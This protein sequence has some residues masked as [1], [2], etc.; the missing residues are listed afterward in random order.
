MS[1]DIVKRCTK[2]GELTISQVHVYK[3]KGKTLRQCLKCNRDR[4][5]KHYETQENRDKKN[6]KDRE[7]WRE[8]KESI[9]KKRKEGNYNANQRKYYY[10][11]IEENREQ[12]KAKQKKYRTE[13]HDSYI[14]R[15]IQAGDKTIPLSSITQ[16]MIQLKRAVM[17]LKGCIKKRKSINIEVKLNDNK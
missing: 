14:K 10:E 8:N 2:H 5:R 9:T 3:Y 17:L 6:A 4:A 12:Y 1:S 15:V 7:R 11:K 16:E 13:L